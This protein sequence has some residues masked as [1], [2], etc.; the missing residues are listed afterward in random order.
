M[1]TNNTTPT[2]PPVPT[3][4]A[5]AVP[6]AVAAASAPNPNAPIQ[7]DPTITSTANPTSH[8]S[9]AWL[10]IIAFMVVALLI[11]F[12]IFM[13][14]QV[15]QNNPELNQVSS[16]VEDSVKSLSDEVKNVVIDDVSADFEEVDSELSD[17]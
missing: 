5:E 4:P 17:L 2:N 15:S 6:P 8:K 3:P 9:K 16:Q 14:M 10:I 1:D 13:Y 12:G 7:P 11:G